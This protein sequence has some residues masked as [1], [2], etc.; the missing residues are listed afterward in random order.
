M[1]GILVPR[2]DTRLDLR[3]LFF[4][5]SKLRHVMCVQYR[6]RYAK[7]PADEAEHH[8]V[9]YGCRELYKATSIQ[10]RFLLTYRHAFINS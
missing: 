7:V 5:L 4:L 2:F 8:R 3:C 1:R 6:F 10:T 9:G